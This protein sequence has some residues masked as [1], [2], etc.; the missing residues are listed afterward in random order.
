MSCLSRR[1]K[2]DS[3]LNILLTNGRFPV[4]IDLARQLHFLSHSVFVIDPMHYHVCKFSRAVRRSFRVP[5]PHVDALGFISAVKSVIKTAKIDLI[6]PM[7]E[8]IFYLAESKDPEIV[9]RMLAPEWDILLR[10]HNKWT[11]SEFLGELGLGRP[12]AQLCQSRADVERVLSGPGEWAVKPVF[13]RAASNVFHLRSGD[14]VPDSCDVSPT[15]HYIAQAWTTGARYCS[16]MVIRHGRIQAFS[17]YPVQDTLDGSSC[18]YFR[19]IAHP[20]IEEYVTRLAA[21]LP[22]V[23]AQLAFDFIDVPGSGLVA[24]ECNPRATSG[25]HLFSGTPLLAQALVS[26][27]P[28]PPSPHQYTSFTVIPPQGAARQI[29][30]GM[31]M[32]K[33]DRG[34]K[35]YAQHMKKLMGSKDVV[36]SGRDVMPSLMQPF[37]LTSYYEICRERRLGLAEM[38]QWD[39]VW[40][41]D[42]GV[43]AKRK[44]GGVEKVR[45]REVER[46]GLVEVQRNEAKESQATS[47]KRDSMMDGETNDTR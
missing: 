28:A 14:A 17:L 21:A 46:V 26:G 1:S 43:T 4:T 13:G 47:A 19:S 33:K 41:P 8:E 24:I 20:G 3:P 39:V 5:T 12:K 25:I 29:A 32:W 37:L 7:H 10:L 30:P 11:F 18:V 35:A 2:N 44:E 16:Y 22:T 6:I 42:T 38:F 9:N 45:E 40:E 27:A 34:V 23:C 31:M 15:N 36:F